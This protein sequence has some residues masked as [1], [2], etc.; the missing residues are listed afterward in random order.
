MGQKYYPK[1]CRASSLFSCGFAVT[2]LCLGVV[3]RAAIGEPKRK[4][5]LK[6]RSASVTEI[7]TSLETLS[8]RPNAKPTTRFPNVGECRLEIY[9]IRRSDRNDNNVIGN[10][11]MRDPATKME[12][13]PSVLTAIDCKLNCDNHAKP[14][15]T[16]IKLRRRF[17]VQG[18]REQG[19]TDNQ[20]SR[21]AQCEGTFC[22]LLR[23]PPECAIYCI[24]AKTRKIRELKIKELVRKSPM[25]RRTQP[26]MDKRP[27][28]D[29]QHVHA[30]TSLPSWTL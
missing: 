29:F 1:K 20:I 2:R 28:D 10:F 5:R 23:F 3:E 7:M 26:T 18:I 11:Q 25:S 4:L 8:E 15:S 12:E 22:S 30:L 27:G 13:T 17:F 21:P 24:K 14:T 19:E 6:I 16:K 9:R